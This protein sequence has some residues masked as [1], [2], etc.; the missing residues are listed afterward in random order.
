MSLKQIVILRQGPKWK[1]GLPLRSQAGVVEHQAHWA[2]WLKKGYLLEGGHF[3]DHSGGLMVC[4]EGITEEQA[5]AFAQSDP[6]VKSGL[7][8]A[9]IKPWYQT[10]TSMV[11][12]P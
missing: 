1:P 10:I 4:A 12:A 9:Y 7:L 5:L 6:A 3:M 11:A 2:K 8:L